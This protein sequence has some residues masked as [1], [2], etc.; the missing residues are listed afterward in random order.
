MNVSRLL[1]G[2]VI[3]GCLL[4]AAPACSLPTKLAARALTAPGDTFTSDDDP[5]LVRK[6][7][8]FG[9]KLQESFLASLPKDGPLLLATCSNFTGYA[10]GFVE[11]DAIV[12][13]EEHHDEA[14]AL[15]DEAL[16]L[17]VRARDYCLRALDV[18]FKGISERLRTS[19][20]T[21]F[22]RIKVKKEDVP[23]LYWTAASWGSA[24]SLGLDRIE[25]VGDFPAVRTLADTAM[26]LDPDWNRGSLYELMMTLDSLPEAMGGAPDNKREQVLRGHFDH[27]VQLQQGLSPG[28]YV[29]MAE[30]IDIAG[31]DPSEFPRLRDQFTR[32]LEQALAIDPNK[33]KSNRLVTL[34]TQR[35]A[36]A[37]LAQIDSR[38]PRIP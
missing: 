29:S 28:P 35:R 12:L 31:K 34:I 18:R 38:I 8:P 10:Y 20:T 7:I 32:L 3:L 11:T 2:L 19:P 22:A 30:H 4:V 24:I 25:L 16:S 14:R 33:D 36:K 9:L 15:R 26:R 23:L 5:E 17:Y 13:G 37:M 1:P 27:A 6:A 21:A